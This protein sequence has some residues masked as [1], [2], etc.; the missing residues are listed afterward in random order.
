[1]TATVPNLALDAGLGERAPF[2]RGG[3]AL[4]H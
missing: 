1:M 2:A 3:K 4:P